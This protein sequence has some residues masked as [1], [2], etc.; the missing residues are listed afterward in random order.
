MVLPGSMKPSTAAGEKK[1]LDCYR[2]SKHSK[3]KWMQVRDVLHVNW[4]KHFPKDK[5]MTFKAYLLPCFLHSVL[6]LLFI[7]GINKVLFTDLSGA[8][9]LQLM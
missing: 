4:K 5:G 8:C 3:Q 7:F 2:Y 1:E 9:S 6:E